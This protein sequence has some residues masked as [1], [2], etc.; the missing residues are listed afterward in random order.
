M[1][2][3]FGLYRSTG[4]LHVFPRSSFL[5]LHS[6]KRILPPPVA[7]CFLLVHAFS[8]R[9]SLSV[10]NDWSNWCWSWICGSLSQL[11]L[12]WQAPFCRIYFYWQAPTHT[13]FSSLVTSPCP[14]HSWIEGMGESWSPPPFPLS[15]VEGGRKERVTPDQKLVCVSVPQRVSGGSYRLSQVIRE[16]VF[17]DGAKTFSFMD[18]AG[19]FHRL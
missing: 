12:R 8:H 3:R 13:N 14:P 6:R 16:E 5:P 7:R 9:E 10:D 18:G 4:W 15:R 11:L 17:R 1:S 19:L 2:Y